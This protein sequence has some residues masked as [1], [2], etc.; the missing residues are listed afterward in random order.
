MAKHKT[1]KELM[2]E[3]NPLNRTAVAPVD[4]YSQPQPTVVQSKEESKPETQMDKPKIVPALTP[5]EK[6]KT[7]V[8]KETTDVVRPYSTYLRQSQVKGIKRRA[9]ETDVKDQHIVQ[10]AI[11]EY[12]ACHPL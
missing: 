6:K 5:I 1:A 10:A 8:Q 7:P 9:V 11:D 4:I 12:F 2:A 3:R